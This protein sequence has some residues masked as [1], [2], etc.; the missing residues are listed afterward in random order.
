MAERLESDMSSLERWLDDKTSEVRTREEAGFPEDVDA[1]IKWNKVSHYQSVKKGRSGSDFF[2]NAALVRWVFLFLAIFS[3]R[4]LKVICFLL[5]Y[6]VRLFLLVIYTLIQSCYKI[7][8]LSLSF[9][10]FIFFL[11]T[12]LK[13]QFQETPVNS[14]YWLSRPDDVLSD[15]QNPGCSVGCLSAVKEYGTVSRLCFTNYAVVL[16]YDRFSQHEHRQDKRNPITLLYKFGSLQRVLL[17][18]VKNVTVWYMMLN[19]IV[20]AVRFSKGVIALIL[21]CSFGPHF[22]LNKVL[23]NSI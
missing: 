8:L 7:L 17:V 3:P 4:R 18:Y 5:S 19:E 22:S 12:P 21:F 16:C 11:L 20:C 15:T 6:S 1:E 10:L 23:L 14:K 2:L 13:A 9:L